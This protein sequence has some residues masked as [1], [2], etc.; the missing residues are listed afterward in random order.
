MPRTYFDMGRSVQFRRMLATAHPDAPPTFQE[1]DPIIADERTIF[2]IDRGCES[3]SVVGTRAPDGSF[4]WIDV[5]PPR[6]LTLEHL[7]QMRVNLI[8]QHAVPW[9]LLGNPNNE[10]R[11]MGITAE[12]GIPY[13][14]S[15]HVPEGQ[16]FLIDGDVLP[17]PTPR[18]DHEAAGLRVSQQCVP[19][20]GPWNRPEWIPGVACICDVCQMFRQERRP[21]WRELRDLAEGGVGPWVIAAIMREHGIEGPFEPTA[22]LRAEDD[23]GDDLGTE[24][25]A[26]LGMGEAE[27]WFRE[28]RDDDL[29]PMPF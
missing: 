8:E 16:M 9:H 7:E 21:T 29:E 25:D 26:M 11:L 13:R 14:T 18:V 17:P 23:E 15:E 24:T 12:H 20:P 28:R 4:T 5:P 10:E 1:I 2:G 19:T 3:S 6:A 22:Q 27:G